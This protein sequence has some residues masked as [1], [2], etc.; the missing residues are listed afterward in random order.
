M[1]RDLLL[2]RVGLVSLACI[3]LTATASAD[4]KLP[5][6][7]GN[8]M[9]LERD[10]A[11]PV[12]GWADPGE[13]VTVSAA[14]Q[15]KTATADSAGKWSVKLDALKA[16]GPIEVT[17]Q[18]NNVIR[19]SDVLVGEVWLCSGQSNMAMTVGSS[20]NAQEEIAAANYPQIRLF[21]VARK[22]A[23]EPQKD[24]QGEWKL[25]SPKTV[26]GFSA[27]GYF[28][29]RELHKQLNVPVGL[30]DSSWGGTPVEGWT[31]LK[32]Q[33]AVPELA[34]RMAGFKKV[35]A[36]YDPEK[37][38]QVYEKQLAKWKL[39][40]AKA[41]EAGQRLPRRP[42]LFDPHFSP[43]SPGRL[44][45]GMI[46]PVAPYAIRGAIWYQGESNAGNAL[47]YGLQMKTMIGNWRNL[48]GEGDF[49]FL[50]VQLPNFM[51]PQQRPSETSGWPLIREQFVKTL[52]V[53][54]TG[55]AVTIDIGEEKDIHPKNKQDVGKRLAQWA[56][57]KTYGKDV[58]ACGPLYKSMKKQGDKIVIEFTYTGGKLAAKGDQLKGFA[59]AGKDKSFVWADAKIEGDRV[60]VS[61]PKVKSPVAVRYAWA[62]NPE[63]NLFNEAGLP[64]S[65]FRTDDWPE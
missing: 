12:W 51:A 56:L 29:G 41:K 59:I 43:H 33:E 63:C 4:V 46:A 20:R 37:A 35:L 40:A 7:F 17:V 2:L 30:I 1:R 21:T 31:C 62:N 64:A 55:M 60:V 45:N 48:W 9:L 28:F 36:N 14:G 57:A 32:A 34:P 38:K 15:S 26:G 47:I 5:A 27:A 6:V 11:V 42:Q 58:V 23:E 18:G 16:G 24:C 22:T 44:F 52:A 8:H 65:P 54:N 61:S 13:K 25:C 39:D 3:G 53:P 49:P 10:A 19:L 50:F